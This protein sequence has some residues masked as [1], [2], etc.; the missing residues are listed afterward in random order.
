MRYWVVATAS[1]GQNKDKKVVSYFSDKL[2]IYCG[3]VD[4]TKLLVT[5]EAILKPRFST[6]T[7]FFIVCIFP[8]SSESC[9]CA[10]H[11]WLRR[12]DAE[13]INWSSLQNCSAPILVKIMNTWINFEMY[14]IRKEK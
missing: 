8:E 4:L 6:A 5:H 1:A 9:L 13:Q 2:K 7:L 12:Q 14:L 3:L 10:N 11:T